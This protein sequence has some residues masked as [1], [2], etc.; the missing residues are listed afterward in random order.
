MRRTNLTL[1]SSVWIP[2]GNFAPEHVIRQQ[3]F[4][5]GVEFRHP[6]WRVGFFV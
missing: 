6:R 4:P 5:G 1:F 2:T 3:R